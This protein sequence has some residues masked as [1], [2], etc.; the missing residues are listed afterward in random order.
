MTGIDI[1]AI[2][3][4]V[5]VIAY[6]INHMRTKV[7]GDGNGGSGSITDGND[8]RHRSKKG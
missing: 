1:F 4:V 3:L 2:I 6:V 8:G 5:G 7:P